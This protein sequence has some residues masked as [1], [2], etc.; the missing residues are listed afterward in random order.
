MRG[1][2]QKFKNKHK[3]EVN[4]IFDSRG[5]KNQ[6]LFAEPWNLEVNMIEMAN[7]LATHIEKSIY[8]AVPKR[9][10]NS[11]KKILNPQIKIINRDN[12]LQFHQ[13]FYESKYFFTA[14]WK[15][16]SSY[17]EEQLVI[18]IWH[19]IPYKTIGLL[20]GNGKGL[21][22]ANVTL[23]TSILTRSIFSKTF[24]VSEETI[25]IA[26][27]PRNDL[28]IRSSEQ[29]KEMKTKIKGNLNSYD[30]VFIW[31]PT[32]RKDFV[33]GHKTHGNPVNNA[34]QVEDFEVEKFNHVLKKQ[35]VLCFVKPHRSRYYPI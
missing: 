23:A 8:F 32:F 20:H 25:F 33:G 31:L 4:K 3:Y 9:L 17:S 16:P 26:G 29:K 18:N 14:H 10:M 12:W 27:Y 13:T 2:F 24:G 28:L 11:A 35:N 19:G 15:F 5:K 1:I 6:I 30:K 21:I 34:F 22:K 7:Y